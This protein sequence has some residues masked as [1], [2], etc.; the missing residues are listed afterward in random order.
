M[1]AQ[2][3]LVLSGHVGPLSPGDLILSRESTEPL[4]ILG[5]RPQALGA[6]RVQPFE[7]GSAGPVV[8]RDFV[9]RAGR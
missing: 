8:V 6:P 1:R 2:R 7:L 9:D 4:P 3:G 5:A